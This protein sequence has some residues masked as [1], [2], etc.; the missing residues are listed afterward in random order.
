[1]STRKKARPT[2]PK[3]IRARLYEG[4][5]Q[6]FNNERDYFRWNAKN[7]SSQLM[8]RGTKFCGRCRDQ[9]GLVLQHTGYNNNT[10]LGLFTLFLF[11][12]IPYHGRR[13]GGV[14]V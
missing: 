2:L 12:G 3:P 7:R 10:G 5:A 6:S 8:R 1:M 9:F 11:D 4:M 13:L 14:T